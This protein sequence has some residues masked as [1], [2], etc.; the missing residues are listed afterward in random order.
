MNRQEFLNELDK[1]LQDISEEDR[2]EALQYY[3]DYFEDAGVENEQNVTR[4][5]ESPEK[6]A[7]IIK[8]D[9]RNDSIR[10]KGEFTEKGYQNP[11]FEHQDNKV[12]NIDRLDNKQDQDSTQWSG[13]NQ[14]NTQQSYHGYTQNN[15]YGQTNQQKKEPEYVYE[16]TKIPK[17]LFIVGLILFIPVGIPVLASI[18]G[19]TVGILGATFG[20]LVGF[21]AASLGLFVSGIAL[22]VFGVAKLFIVPLL[23]LFCCGAG[24]VLIGVA[25][26]FAVVTR[27][28]A[29]IFPIVI[30]GM[31]GICKLPFRR[32]VMA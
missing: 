12:A 10:E 3:N 31:I 19:I 15:A 8:E 2:T 14:D 9:L 26:L 4:E 23:G 27:L 20:I 32:K 30:N 22:L 11:S 17:W 16:Y 18:F 25:A 1:L 5:L 6:V 13:Q 29:K 7:A 28:A 21:G 24:L